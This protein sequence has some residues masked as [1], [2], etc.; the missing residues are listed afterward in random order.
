[1]LR[2][3]LIVTI[4]VSLLLQA[5]REAPS[6]VGAKT[7]V[8]L[9]GRFSISLPERNGFGPLTI[10]TPFGEAKGDLSHWETK[11][12]TFGVGHADAAMPLDGPVARKQF[13]DGDIER[14]NKVASSNNG[15]VAAVKQITLDKYPG[16]EQRVDLFTGSVVQRTYIVSRR[17][18]EIVAVLRNSQRVYESVALGVLDSFKVLSDAEVTAR[19]AQE[20]A[21]AEPSPLPQTP[22]PRRAGSDASDEGLRGRVKSVLSESEDLSGTWSVQ[23]RKRDLLDTYNEQGN[24]VRTEEYDSRGNLSA[25]TVYG[26]IDGSR[27]SAFNSIDR[28]YNPPPLIV[29]VAPAPGAEIKKPDPRYQYRFGFKYDDKKRLTEMTYFQSTGEIWLRYVYKYKGNQTEELVYSEDGSLNQRSLH[30]LDDQGNEIEET[31]FETNGSIRAKE[32]FTY[33][34]D[35]QGNWTTRT[36]SKIV[37]DEKREQSIPYSVRFRTITYY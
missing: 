6:V 17:V 27:V 5:Q 1:M 7:F 26:Y 14:F 35:A 23:G 37:M 11:E 2:L 20:A 9:E 28:E 10:P 30:V 18:Y 19:Q 12:A 31:I 34:F 29:S 24:R 15:N 22:V 16:I 32:K 4:A 33:K 13:F 21:K 36:T 8:S 25:I 3:S